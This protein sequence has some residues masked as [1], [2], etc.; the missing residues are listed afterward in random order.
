MNSKSKI[1]FGLYIFYLLSVV[2]LLVIPI[3]SDLEMDKYI[4]GIRKDHYVHATMFLPF[5]GY[6]WIAEK[7]QKSK[8]NLLKF[9]GL[10]ICFAA[11][12]ESLHYF[13]PYRT[14][15]LQDFVAN[16]TG[17]SLG[18]ILFLFKVP[19]IFRQ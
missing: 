2:T 12:C 8:I 16:A 5:L 18:L 4:F 7:T 15:D 9:Y 14:F 1:I 13:I 6:F 3:S 10:G 11:I 17:L 19:K